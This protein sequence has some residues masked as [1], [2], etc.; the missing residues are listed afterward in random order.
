MNEKSKNKFLEDY[1]VKDVL[2]KSK[3]LQDSNKGLI[4]NLMKKQET[5]ES[6]QINTDPLVLLE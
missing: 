5:G 6:K 1:L 4:K 2:P 3:I